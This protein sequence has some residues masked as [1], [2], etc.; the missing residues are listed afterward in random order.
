[1]AW[2]RCCGGN[3]KPGVITGH[4]DVGTINPTTFYADYEGTRYGAVGSTITV[5]GLYSMTYTS[6]QVWHVTA[7]RN[8]VYMDSA[9][10][11]VN[12]SAGIQTNI[13][14]STIVDFSVTFN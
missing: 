10:T 8:A 1:M 9:G 12:L 6:A 13:T 3:K 14:I 4:I 2:V 7:M 11:I 5:P